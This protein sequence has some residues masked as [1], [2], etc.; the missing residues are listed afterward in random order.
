[1]QGI[2]KEINGLLA[3]LDGLIEKKNRLQAA[4]LLAYDEEKL[5]ILE[6]QVEKISKEVNEVRERL[7]KMMVILE[8]QAENITN[9]VII[10][11]DKPK[12]L[13]PTTFANP[14]KTTSGPKKVFVSLSK[15]D[16]SFLEELKLHLA[17]FIR[18][19]KIT[20]FDYGDILPGEDL[21]A[22]RSHELAS[23]DLILML[24]SANYTANDY[25][26]KIEVPKAMELHE[27]G[28]AI[29][30]PILISHCIWDNMPFSLLNTLP[31]KDLFVSDFKNKNAAWLEVVKGV[32]RVIE[33]FNSTK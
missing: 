23:A 25:V 2:E 10:V 33:D 13:S 32:N 1:M 20:L 5:F 30:I 14:K 11:H 8:K 12:N 28:I 27:S 6:K 21:D 24:I 9:K 29:V 16:H 19:N 18:T 26:W 3:Y 22:K 15:E 7:Q 31:G 4:I 17:P